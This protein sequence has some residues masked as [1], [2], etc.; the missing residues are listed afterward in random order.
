MA[1]KAVEDS[2]ALEAVAVQVRQLRS[3]GV[4][5]VRGAQHSEE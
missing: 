1:S 2:E 3:A 4:S 5:Y